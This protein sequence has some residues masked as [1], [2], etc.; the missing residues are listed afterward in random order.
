MTSKPDLVSWAGDSFNKLHAPGGG[1]AL[2]LV[3]MDEQHLLW[4]LQFDTHRFPLPDDAITRD[5]AGAAALQT[6]V[7][8]LASDLGDP[9]PEIFASTDFSRVYCFRPADTD[10]IPCFY[11]QNL[12]LV[13]DA[14]HPLST[15][16]SQGVSS[17]I[18]DAVALAHEIGPGT[19]T[20]K[21]LARAL[22]HYSAVR[23]EQCAPFI[24][25]ARELTETFVAPLSMRSPVLPI[26]LP[27]SDRE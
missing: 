10:L 27:G 7:T 12:A 13:G 4:Y 19:R 21:D 26:A 18:A 3:P 24:E 5:R 23:R 6:F 15:F 8:K 20:E 22:A 11:Q 25:K 1:V 16:T 17:A 14:A 9:V 2:G